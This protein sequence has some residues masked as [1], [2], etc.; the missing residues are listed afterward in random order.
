MSLKEQLDCCRGKL[1]QGAVRRSLL[2]A[3]WGRMLKWPQD[4]EW[5]GVVA[6]SSSC[7]HSGAQEAV[8]SQPSLLD[9]KGKEWHCQW[10][11]AAWHAGLTPGP[12]FTWPLLFS[13]SVPRFLF[14]FF[15]KL[16]AF[17]WGAPLKQRRGSGYVQRGVKSEQFFLE[18]AVWK[19]RAYNSGTA[20]NFPRK[21]G[22]CFKCFPRQPLCN[23]AK[24]QK[25]ALLRTTI[26]ICED[27]CSWNQEFFQFPRSESLLF[28]VLFMN[29]AEGRKSGAPCLQT[30][31]EQW[32]FRWAEIRTF[33]HPSYLVNKH[34][35]CS[36]PHQALGR[37]W[38]TPMT[39]PGPKRAAHPVGD[40]SWSCASHSS[41][42]G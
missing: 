2:Q 8:G 18:C 12:Y 32:S 17:T 22:F 42:S 39:W 23:L 9:E 24:H 29:G 41:C 13:L 1:E 30:M 14:F 26:Q 16:W 4:V 35:S 40:W 3:R 21:D 11:C 37:T 36:V 6:V 25:V 27:L 7:A 33:L 31:K 38:K 5:S 28:N 10:V 19:V 34:F 15:L 20:C